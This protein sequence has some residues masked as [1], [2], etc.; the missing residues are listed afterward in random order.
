MLDALLPRVCNKHS[1]NGS[2]ISPIIQLVPNNQCARLMWNAPKQSDNDLI[3][4]RCLDA[5][6]KCSVQLK[7]FRIAL[8]ILGIVPAHLKV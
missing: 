7:G 8:I 6:E 3:H 2:K 4:P 5:L 1:H